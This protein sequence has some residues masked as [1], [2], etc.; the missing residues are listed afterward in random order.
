MCISKYEHKKQNLTF[1]IIIS[2]NQNNFSRGFATG[3]NIDI[4]L[5]WF[6]YNGIMHQIMH[7]PSENLKNFSRGLRPRTPKIFANAICTM[8]VI[9]N[10]KA[11]WEWYPK[12]FSLWFEL[13]WQLVYVFVFSAV[14][15]FI[16]SIHNHQSSD[17]SF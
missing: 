9:N 1:F 16:F 6:V 8:D 15:H 13:R 3:P 11:T 17:F 14:P 4:S 12:S 5:A 2:K 10:G 7:F